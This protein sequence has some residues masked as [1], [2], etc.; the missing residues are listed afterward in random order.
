MLYVVKDGEGDAVALWS[1]P[2]VLD[3][4]GGLVAW[5]QSEATAAEIARRWNAHEAL[6]AACEMAA[7]FMPAGTVVDSRGRRNGEKVE[8]ALLAAL[9]K[10]KA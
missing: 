10:A 4:D 9:A 5:A 2:D 3:L 6:V 1:R 7:K 8:K